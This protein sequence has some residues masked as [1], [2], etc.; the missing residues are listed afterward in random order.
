MGSAFVL[1]AIASLVLQHGFQAGVRYGRFFEW[2]DL[3]L[4][5]GLSGAILA[6]LLTAR[7]RRQELRALRFEVVLLGVFGTG[8]LASWALPEQ[9]RS[10]EEVVARIGGATDLR[11]IWVQMFLLVAACLQTLRFLQRVFA[12]GLKPELLLAGSFAALILLGTLLLLVP[13]ASARPE[14]P[15][16]VVDA[17]FTATSATCVT[18]LVVRDTG[19]DF[20]TMG[21]MVILALFQVGGLGIITFVA[22]VS[23]FSTRTLPVPQLLAL[24]QIISAPN[25]SLVKR[26]LGG[27]VFLTI[28]VELAGAVGLFFALPAGE[29]IE[30]LK[31]SVFHSVSAFCNAGF[32]L[33]ADS[34]EG[35]RGSVPVNGII[36]ALIVTGGLGFLVIGEG[37]EMMIQRA[38]RVRA[39]FGGRRHRFLRPRAPRLSVQ[40]RISL[41]VTGC[42]VLVGLTGFLFLEWGHIL[43]GRSPTESI[44]ISAFQSVTT[45]TAGF[46]TVTIGDLQPATVF[47]LMGLMVIGGCPVSAAGGIKTVTFGILLL[48]IRAM[49]THRQQVEAYGRMLPPRALFAA[50]SVSVLYVMAAAGGVFLL[51]VFEPHLGLRDQ[52]FEVVSALSTV[53]LSTGITAGLSPAGKLVLCGLMF[54]GRVGPI[55]LVFSIVQ[56]RQNVD[57]QFPEEDV[58]V[59]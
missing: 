6:S 5:V 45:R 53:G 38:R 15:V 42:L 34:L 22:F 48:T 33:Q 9:A 24:R 50:L 39:G 23:V 21:Q 41:W 31:W 8:F 4:A 28:T 35:L 12:L 44:L 32:A 51:S 29:P 17:L 25:V 14:H 58:V 30:R 36:M 19:T 2:V 43:A 7:N 37:V 55:S 16:G 56:A 54:I 27:I 57:Y 52:A 1:V 20:S 11:S 10:F 26:Q 46:N 40:T 47:L 59:G 3:I 13:R 49:F 18:G